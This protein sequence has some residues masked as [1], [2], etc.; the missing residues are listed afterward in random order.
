LEAKAQHLPQKKK[1]FLSLQ[2]FANDGKL[3]HQMFSILIA[4]Y[5]HRVN[6]KALATIVK[7]FH[8]EAVTF[9]ATPSPI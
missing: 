2:K 8:H 5:K 4:L 7:E 3:G 9:F 6:S 1:T